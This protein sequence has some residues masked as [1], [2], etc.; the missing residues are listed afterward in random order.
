[1]WYFWDFR[2]APEELAHLSSLPA[3]KTETDSAQKED[4]HIG[5]SASNDK[6]FNVTIQ[7]YGLVCD[8]DVPETVVLNH[9][10]I[11]DFEYANVTGVDKDVNDEEK[12]P[13]LLC[14]GQEC[15]KFNQIP[16]PVIPFIKV[17][18]INSAK[19]T[20]AASTP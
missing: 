5:V 20:P 6:P 15:T 3:A 9:D 13:V 7:R 19:A 18:A 16:Y 1:M 11:I 10:E 4:G 12:K 14:T 2:P 8:S 17:N